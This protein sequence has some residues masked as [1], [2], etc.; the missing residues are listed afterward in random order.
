MSTIIFKHPHF[1]YKFGITIIAITFFLNANAQGGVL[2]D[3]FG[4]NG[5]VLANFTTINQWGTCMAVQSDGKVLLAGWG[6]KVSQ[7]Y[8]TKIIIA[9]FHSNGEIDNTFGING[10]TI[11]E[12]IKAELYAHSITIQ[13]NGKILVSGYLKTMA[14]FDFLLLQFN[15]EGNLDTSLGDEGIVITDFY[16][17]NDKAYSMELLSD[18]KIVIAGTIQNGN[19]ND[20]GLVQFHPDGSIDTSFGQLG[21]VVTDFGNGF[22]DNG[23]ALAIQEDEKIIITGRTGHPSNHQFGI[24]RYNSDGSLDGSFGIGGRSSI[25]LQ[26]FQDAPSNLAIQNDGKIII[27]GISNGPAISGASALI[28]LQ[29][30]GEIDDSFGNNG[31]VL[32]DIQGTSPDYFTSVHYLTDGKILAGGTSFGWFIIVRYHSN[33]LIDT[34]F[35]NDGIYSFFPGVGPAGGIIEEMVILENGNILCG[36]S[37][38]NGTNNDFALMRL[39]PSGVMDSLFSGNGLIKID[40][41]A[42]NTGNSI[43]LRHDGKILVTGGAFRRYSEGYEVA[44]M[45]FNENGTLNSSFAGSGYRLTNISFSHDY[46]NSVILQPDGKVIVTGTSLQRTEDSIKRAILI[47]YVQIGNTDFT[48]NQNGIIN[49]DFGVPSSEGIE[50]IIQP[51]SKIVTL[52]CLNASTTDNIQGIGLIRHN[53]DGTIDSTFGTNGIVVFTGVVSYDPKS[54]LILPDGK[55]L[56]IASVSSEDSSSIFLMQYTSDGQLDQTFGINGNTT[57]SLLGGNCFAAGF[58]LLPSGKLIIAGRFK[59]SLTNSSSLELVRKFYSEF[60]KSRCRTMVVLAKSTQDSED[61]TVY[62]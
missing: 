48:F 3:D 9:R 61:N 39:L 30:N 18:G 38:V 44:L 20:F 41:P 45:N 47:R 32:T 11:F 23:A 37:A 40:F 62:S 52:A 5:V 28:R 15:S 29:P 21:K 1:I 55:L 49:I 42:D 57:L 12:S 36:G 43:S 17:G 46:G 27:G 59:N 22:D 31:I 33:G 53:P 58:E 25:D 19:H 7:E 26:S 8:E 14:G 56:I 24:A 10:F 35:G 6:D 2:V 60:G 51:D 4:D 16:N 54:I 34:S 50:S 13:Q